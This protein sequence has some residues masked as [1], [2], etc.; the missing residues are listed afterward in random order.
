[1]KALIHT[2]LYNPL[3]NLLIF[4]A[5]LVPG[6]SIAIAIIL[7]TVVI[8]LLLLPSAIKAA[9]FQV[10]SL[11]IQPKVNKIRTEIKDQQQQSQ[12]LMALYKEEGYSPFGSCLPLLIQIPVIWVLFAVFKSGLQA[13]NYAGLYSFIPRPEVVN[14]YFLGLDITKPDPW[15][16]PIVAGVLQLGLSY[17]TM[18]PQKSMLSQSGNDSAA[19]MSK[20]MLIIAPIIT[21][22][23]GHTMPAALV[24]YWITT[25]VFGI[26]QQF[27]VNKQIRAM[28]QGKEATIETVSS[29]PRLIEKKEKPTK[30]DMLSEIMDKRLN[31]QAQKT[32]VNVTVRTKKK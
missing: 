32:G 13:G 7:L 27:Y 15:L 29:A 10:K 2:I 24:I 22:F 14:T 11:K 9:H 5:W 4:F 30:K 17:L 28:D 21:V 20:Q 18:L 6:H 19:M 8:R 1:M 16:L 25:T 23:F 12:A 3:F 26:G 31:K